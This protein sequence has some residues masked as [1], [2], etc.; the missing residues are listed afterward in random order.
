MKIRTLALVLSLSFTSAPLPAQVTETQTATTQEIQ[1]TVPQ[2]ALVE[3][4]T[5]PLDVTTLPANDPIQIDLSFLNIPTGANDLAQGVVAKGYARSVDVDGKKIGQVVLT[6]VAKGQREETLNSALF[7]S[8]F[9]MKEEAIKPEE[10]ITIMGNGPEL[11]EALKRLQAEPAKEEEAPKEAVAQSDSPESTSTGE[12]ANPDAASYQS[13]DPIEKKAAPVE[14][15]NITTEG[16][17]IRV[18]E[19]QKTAF[20]Q[21]KIQNLKDGVVQSEEACTDSQVSYKLEKSYSNCKGQDIIDLT[22]SPATAT[23]QFQW[24]YVDGGGT[25]QTY[26]DCQPDPELKFEIV[27]K[28]DS[29]PIFL[30]YTAGAEKAV[31]QS[32]LVYMNQ[33]NKEELVR[34][35]AASVEKPAVPM[36]LST[37]ACHDLRHEYA[38]VNKSYRQ[39]VWTYQ[40]NGVTYQ[41]GNCLDDGT[42]YPHVKTYKDDAGKYLCTPINNGSTV[43]LQYRMKITVDGLSQYV[44]ECTPDT[45]NIAIKSTTQDCTDP[46]KWDH[47]VATGQ[48]YGQE[49]FYFVHDGKE[50]PVS[51]CQNSSTIYPHDQE[52]VDWEEH[53]DQRFAYP[54][55]TVFITPPSGRYNIKTSEVLV[56]AQQMPYTFQ[57]FD[58]IASG[59][60]TYEGCNKLQGYDNVKVWKRPDGT[61]YNEVTGAAAATSSNACTTTGGI[62]LTDWINSSSSITNYCSSTAQAQTTGENGSTNYIYTYYGNSYRTCK[63]TSTVKVIRDDGEI[64]SSQTFTETS[65]TTYAGSP[66]G[67][68]QSGIGNLCSSSYSGAAGN[69]PPICPAT[70][71]TSDVA[72][73]R[74]KHGY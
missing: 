34:D 43:T 14:T 26:G 18:D 73:W 54:K 20:V 4:L 9:D 33:S 8:Q 32:K 12:S 41:A 61:L 67:L 63:Y 64:V 3:I 30:D 57:K 56:G 24:Y 50:V 40:S 66:R 62:A 1:N 11:I 22:T 58:V 45:S 70:P 68:N 72:T 53:D 69:T 35:C 16:C 19:K 36:A 65:A 44:T 48:S 60:P 6:G 29:C 5:A 10:T 7:T 59:S 74:A 17:G 28:H 52:T 39:S 71:S 51:E 25:N 46:S 15:V 21:S 49:R 13:P 2:S 27:E 55:T 38:P 42:E 31:F 47:N 23:A 37:T